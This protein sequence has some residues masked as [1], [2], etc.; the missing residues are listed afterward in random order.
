[1]RPASPLVLRRVPGAQGPVVVLAGLAVG[2]GVL[3]VAQAVVLAW[4]ITQVATGGDLLAPAWALLTVLAG[5]GLVALGSETGAGWAG[6]R[7]SAGLRLAVLRRWLH[8]PESERPAPETAVTLA[9]DG[10][11][12]VEAYVARYLPALVAAA[13]VPAL[14]LAVLVVVDVWSA[15]IVLLTLPL[16]PF[17]AAL[18]GRHTQAETQRRWAALT[19]LSGHFLDVVRGLP[20]LVGYGRAEHQ[21]GV[22]AEVGERHRKA[23]VRTLKTAFLSTAAL[24]LL[25]TISVALVAVAVGLRLAYGWLPLQVGLT[26]ILLAPE[27]YWPVRRVGTEF[28]NAVDGQ[29]ALT[30]LL[31]P[32]G[33]VKGSDSTPT[34]RVNGS[35]STPTGRAVWRVSGSYAYPGREAVLTGVDLATEPGPGLTVLTGRSGG[36]KTTVLDLL[37]GLR[38]PVP[39]EVVAPDRVHYAT[40]RPLLVPGTVRDNLALT[41]AELTDDRAEQALRKV[42]LW[43]ALAARQGLDT[44]LGDDGFGLSA[45]QRARLAL[46]RALVSDA[47]LV[48]LDEPTAHVAADSRSDLHALIGTL[49]SR[50]RVVVATHDPDLAAG[51]DQQWSLPGAATAVPTEPAATPERAATSEPAATPTIR[52]ATAAESPTTPPQPPTPPEPTSHT[53]SERRR[54]ALACLLGGLSAACGV[55]LTATSGWLIVRAWQQPVVL[56]L[57]VAIVGVRAFG[58]GRPVFRYAERVVSHDLL[59]GVLARRRRE[60]YARLIPLT[61]ARLGRRSRADLLTAVVRDLDD[62]VNARARVTV[63]LWSAALASAVA[64]TIVAL[65][66]PAAGVMI[67]LA[68]LAAYALGLI[69]QRLERPA[70]TAEVRARAALRHRATGLSAQLEAH[71]AVLGGRTAAVLDPVRAAQDAQ[72][73]AVLRSGLCRGAGMALSWLLVGLTTV[74][75]ATLATTAYATGTVSAPLAALVA[76]TPVALADIWVGLPEVFGQRARAAVAAERLDTVLDQTPAVADRADATTDPCHRTTGTID[77]HAVS[78]R[79]SP[80]GP[81]DLAPL[82]L[83]V[84]PGQRIVLTGPNGAGKSTALAVMARHLDPAGGRYELSG[85]DVRD[86][87]LAQTRR[88]VAVVDDEPHVFAGT[89]RANLAL[90]RPDCTDADIVAALAAAGLDSWRAALPD[91]LD[92]ALTGLSGG[93][94][95]RMALARAMLS[96]RRVLLLDEPTAHL[97][98]PTAAQVLAE[99]VRG[100]R[101]QTVVMVSHD[102]TRRVDPRHWTVL[103]ADVWA[104]PPTPRELCSASATP[105]RPSEPAPSLSR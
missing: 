62:V 41:A 91:G 81:L 96:G 71:R 35:D 61:P 79:W 58:I 20:T 34:G 77:L 11:T 86:V 88:Q 2:G 68:T 100:C 84:V 63:P 22:V 32:T 33:R 52:P 37:A 99:L 5:R 75:V 94:R 95:T 97:D 104:T 9:T 24:E 16:L 25:A 28:H 3:A 73:R 40:Q 10:T 92:T 85:Q 87:P 46:A 31:P 48:L 54:L 38:Q 43:P 4:L 66:L 98:G 105:V 13:L 30:T 101:M 93:E 29:Q 64:A 6:Q 27:A 56:T 102:E 26:A 23:T 80:G 72:R 55:A 65:V 44:P 103:P 78:A 7:I 12:A 42:G 50:R 14:T 36:G 60:L 57:L 67:A 89:V 82:D 47:A 70:H 49:A 39:G 17:F 15:L 45:G 19:T 1:M 69:G 8:A 59:L 76:L 74:V 51:A 90:A 18:I 21:V 53:S 83:H